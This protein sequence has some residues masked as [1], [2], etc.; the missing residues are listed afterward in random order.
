MKYMQRLRLL[1]LEFFGFVEFRD[2]APGALSPGNE[3]PNLRTRF[4]R[5]ELLYIVLY[6][7]FGMLKVSSKSTRRQL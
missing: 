2:V 3:Y 5:K 4:L 1:N 6:H 7:L